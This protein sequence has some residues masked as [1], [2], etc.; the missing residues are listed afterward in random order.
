MNN[1]EGNITNIPFEEIWQSHES[2]KY[3]RRP[4][5]DN[6]QGY[7]TKCEHKYV[8]RGGCPTNCKAKD[9]S[10]YCL[11]KIEQVGTSDNPK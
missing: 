3:N 1:S 11:Y 9:G 10:A 6:L 5:I 8:C 7:C 2:F 4:N